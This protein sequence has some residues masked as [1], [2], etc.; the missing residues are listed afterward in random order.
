[1]LLIE[2]HFPCIKKAYVDGSAHELGVG[3]A[4]IFSR[5]GDCGDFKLF[6]P[7]KMSPESPFIFSLVY[8]PMQKK[9]T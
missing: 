3:K 6:A 2:K 4:G 5:G 9:I 1:M 7:L 8:N